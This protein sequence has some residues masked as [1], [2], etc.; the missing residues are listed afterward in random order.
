MSGLE[1]LH[2][3]FDPHN[4]PLRYIFSDSI[5][6]TFFAL[7]RMLEDVTMSFNTAQQLQEVSVWPLILRVTNSVRVCHDTV[8][9]SKTKKVWFE[10]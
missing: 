9:I 7:P 3:T 6:T 2:F 4:L 10:A 8:Y 1:F 5:G